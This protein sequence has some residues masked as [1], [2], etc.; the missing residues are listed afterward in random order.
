MYFLYV[1][2]W[3]FINFILTIHFCNVSSLKQGSKYT[4]WACRLHYRIKLTSLCLAWIEW[5][6]CWIWS[7]A[8]IHSNSHS[9][10]LLNVRC[11]VFVDKTIPSRETIKYKINF[12]KRS[13]NF[14]HLEQ[15]LYGQVIVNERIWK[16]FILLLL[17]FF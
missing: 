14:N 7:Q 4:Y 10:I 6:G 13:R 2:V 17:L 15:K 16:F 3:I 12:F 11:I 5:R 8:S 1:C 9:F